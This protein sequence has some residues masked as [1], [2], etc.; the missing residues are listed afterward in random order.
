[1]KIIARILF[2]LLLSSPLAGQ[3]EWE[4]YNQIVSVSGKNP[5]EVAQ[6]IT[7]GYST[8]DEKVQ[9]I[10]Y[11][12]THNISYD[13]KMYEKL[14]KSKSDKKKYSS[15]EIKEKEN[16]EVIKTLKSKKGVC[17]QYS[18]T[19]QSLC[20]AIGIQ[21]KF[22]GGYGR[23]NATKSGLGE[24]HAWNAV[25]LN[26]NWHLVD[27]TWGAGYVNEKKKFLFSFEP[28]YYSANAEAFKMNHL[29]TQSKWQLTD[30]VIDKT[31]FKAHPGVGAG[32][33]KYNLSTLTPNSSKLTIE[34]G[35]PLEV[36]FTSPEKLEHLSVFSIRKGQEIDVDLKHN[37]GRYSITINTDE[38]KSGSY[39][40]FNGKNLLFA[41]RISP[42]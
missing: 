18:R 35:T 1:M 23:A 26:D 21:C 30:N 9:A 32:F 11:W 29:P 25:Y 15:K 2:L 5:V 16:K 6:A 42:N 41:Y 27:A 40:F 14:K 8:D 38:L 31:S 17:Q 20:E 3:I 7:K 13:Q 10:Y 19:F 33:I 28:A 24:K 36:S 34:R 12:V 4:K 37:E 22:I 39:G